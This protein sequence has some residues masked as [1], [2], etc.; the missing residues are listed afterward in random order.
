VSESF[1]H[2]VLEETFEVLM[3][4]IWIEEED[5]LSKPIFADDTGGIIS[6]KIFCDF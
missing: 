6:N 4:N 5:T 1:N 3:R 2:N